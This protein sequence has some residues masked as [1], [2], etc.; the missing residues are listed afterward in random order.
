MAKRTWLLLG[1]VM[2]LASAASAAPQTASEP[3]GIKAYEEQEFI[4]DFTKFKIGD[5][6]PAPG[7][8]AVDTV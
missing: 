3:G 5:T 4:A 7:G 2:S 1:V 8:Y 6:A